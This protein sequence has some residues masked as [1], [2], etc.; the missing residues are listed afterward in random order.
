MILWNIFKALL[1]IL[2]GFPVA[3]VGVVAWWVPYRLCGTIANRV[4]GA[5]KQRDQ[6][7]LYKLLS[8]ALLFPITLTVWTA[9]AWVLGGAAWGV[10]VLLALP[11]AGIS[12]LLF[13]EYASW[14]ESQARELLALAF[15]PGGIARLRGRR[16]IL[17]AECDRLAGVFRRASDN[18]AR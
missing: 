17:V 1:F 6:I 8:G 7:A 12:S 11:F 14:R 4:P 18:P 3:V 2:L 10:L 16:D 9:T 5:S 13:F 15:T